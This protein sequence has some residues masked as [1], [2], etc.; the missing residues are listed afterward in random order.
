MG[1]ARP[2]ANARILVIWAS[3]L[4]SGRA[5]FNQNFCK[6]AAR[7]ISASRF[8][9]CRRHQTQSW[10]HDLNYSAQY[11]CGDQS[12]RRSWAC[13][14]ECRSSPTWQ[15]RAGLG[16]KRGFWFWRRRNQKPR[17]TVLPFRLTAWRIGSVSRSGVEPA[18]EQRAI[19]PLVEARAQ[20]AECVLDGWILGEVV[21]F[22]GVV[23]EMVELFADFDF[24]A[25]VGPL[26]ILE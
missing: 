10:E 8:R 5:D 24:A 26:R 9:P 20:S 15:I 6:S 21:L 12:E 16:V 4:Q 17:L 23:G 14:L 11:S 2:R 3:G 13:R 22:T 19:G 1:S 7:C 18:R 25:H